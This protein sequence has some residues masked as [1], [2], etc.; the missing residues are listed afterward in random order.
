MFSGIN[1]FITRVKLIQSHPMSIKKGNFWTVAC[2]WN[3]N[4]FPL[5]TARLITRAPLNVS[6]MKC[7]YIIYRENMTIFY[8]ILGIFSSID[9]AAWSVVVWSRWQK[10]PKCLELFAAFLPSFQSTLEC[11]LSLFCLGIF[12]PKC[13]FALFFFIK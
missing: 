10:R 3:K 7:S 12:Y 8:L 1:A 13:T 9:F 5:N 4:K 2:Y 6:T 11:S